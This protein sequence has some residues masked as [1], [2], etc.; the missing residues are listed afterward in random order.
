MEKL[1]NPTWIIPESLKDKYPEYETGIPPGPD[2]P[3]GQFALRLSRPDYLIHGTNKPLGVGR[4][5]S[6]G[7]IRMYPEDIRELYSLVQN[8]EEVIILYQPVKLGERGGIPY[9]EVHE[10]Y[11]KADDSAQS[12][13]SLLQ[14]RGLFRKA[15]LSLMFQAVKE[16]RGVPVSLGS[17]PTVFNTDVPDKD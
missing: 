6:H 4:R 7:C 15:D 1:T 17:E 13:V 14:K 12:A 8:G 10:D 3:L 2:N 5:V 16:K 9:I 11:L